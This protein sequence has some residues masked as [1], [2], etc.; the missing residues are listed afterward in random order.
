MMEAYQDGIANMDTTNFYPEAI[1]AVNKWKLDPYSWAGKY[2]YGIEKDYRL[3]KVAKVGCYFYGDGLAQIVHGDGLDSFKYSKNYVGL[4]AEN[5]NIEDSQKAKFS[6]LVSNPP[7]SVTAF[8]GDIK[9]VN[10]SQEF[11]LYKYL[12]DR[13]SEIECL[14]VERMKQL[15]K[16]G[17]LAGIILPS[18]ILT[19][20]GI[21]TKT[22]ELLLKYFE[23]VAITE[24]GSNTFMATGTNTVVLFL[25]RR[26]NY[27]CVN[28][29]KAVDK[30]FKDHQDVTIHG[31][32]TPVA[33]YV[34]RV[35]EGLTFDDY[36]TL[37]NKTPNERVQS[38]D[39]YK[40]Y[41]QKLKAKTEQAFWDKVIGLEKEKLYYFILAYPQ[42]LVVVHTGAKEAEK[43]FLGYEFSNRRGAEGIHPIQKSK[44]IDECTKLFDPH[45]F[46]NPQK[47]ST[48]I[49]KAFEGDTK[50][51]IDETLKNNVSRV[52]L[53]DMMT[54]DRA[55]FEKVINVKAKKKETIESKYPITSLGNIDDLLFKK[56]KSITEQRAKKG[57]IPVVAGGTDVAYYHN[58]ANRKPN[59]ITVSASGANAGFLNFW[60]KPIWASDCSTITSANENVIN[61]TY[62][63]AFLK[64][65]QSQ[66]YSLQ[67]GNAQPH[68]YIEDL[69]R[70]KIPLPPIE[71]QQQI[72]SEISAVE[73]KIVELEKNIQNLNVQIRSLLTQIKSATTR[74]GNICES[75]I[76]LTYRPEDID[77]NGI[78][79]LRSSNIQNG[80]LDL[81]DQV[82]VSCKIRENLYIK[83][84]DVLVCVRNGSKRLL[85]KSA[86]IEKLT[87]PMTFGA[88]MAICRSPMGKYTYI[89]MQSE[90]YARQVEN[91]G[92]TMSINQL[93]QKMLMDL[94]IPVLS[95]K[96]QQDIVFQF[97]KLEQQ[98]TE[99][100]KTI[101]SS[102]QQKQA[103]LDKYLK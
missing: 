13:S 27:E 52:A 42:K 47:A 78:L 84:G 48:Y 76:G 2:I 45:T 85:G 60:D 99:A 37:L 66:V 102:E 12:T 1:T 30:F 40:E 92:T 72:V 26:N 44:T 46:T 51:E 64:S 80:K 50:S 98:I 54:F 15:L 63:Y 34:A 70:L 79:V 89:W 6:I 19:N 86:Y 71:V 101:E 96:A 56:G 87:E 57:D 4:L 9:N 68:V 69:K 81:S 97:E 91:L 58:T 16:D 39:L 8:K 20:S 22:R 36:V 77:R 32:E 43:Q 5:T 61:I 24:L 73:K 41:K 53:L 14:F 55:D 11:E 59:V 10:V 29:Q 49:Y 82:R 67:K 88:F 94:Q 17:G 95:Q 7:Y 90:D 28:L 93:T 75:Y 35:W 74:L 62:V 18:S 33:K 23:F 21:Y 100:Q 31:V 103:I 25:R 38:H 65:I 83:P 3:V